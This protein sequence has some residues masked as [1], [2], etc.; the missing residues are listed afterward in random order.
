[1]FHQATAARASRIEH[2]LHL[3]E[4]V[5]LLLTLACCSQHLAQSF[6]PGWF[7]VSGRLLTFCCAVFPAAGA[8]LAGISNHGE[9]RRIAQRS[10]SMT[11]R[12]THQLENLRRLRQQL[13]NPDSSQ[14][15]LSPEIAALAGEIARTMVNEVLDWRIIFQDRPLKTT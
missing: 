10:A 7:H 2:R 1:M 13:D 12:L 11:E 5:L 3:L 4:V 9:F 15:Q 8:A 14:K 6:W